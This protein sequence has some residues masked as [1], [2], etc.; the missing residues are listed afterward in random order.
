MGHE[1]VPNFNE[2][3]KCVSKCK[4]DLAFFVFL[5]SI[6]FFLYLLGLLK[7]VSRKKVVTLQLL[8]IVIEL[9]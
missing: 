6:L 3:K 1:I 4:M 2:W 7:L 9:V 5:A 8:S